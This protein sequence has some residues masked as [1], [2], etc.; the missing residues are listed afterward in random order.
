VVHGTLGLYDREITDQKVGVGGHGSQTILLNRADE[1]TAHMH[2]GMHSQ[3]F[4]SK[5]ADN[6]IFGH[7]C[8]I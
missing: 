7:T 8:K 3:P 5:A 6:V 4:I 1:N 2:K